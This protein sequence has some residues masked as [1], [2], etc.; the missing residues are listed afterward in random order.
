MDI[1]TFSAT[2]RKDASDLSNAVQVKEGCSREWFDICRERRSVKFQA[3]SESQEQSKNQAEVSK[4][5]RQE[6]G[7]KTQTWLYTGINIKHL[8]ER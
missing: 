8:L 4:G 5:A 3:K 1:A 7:S 6:Q 2:L